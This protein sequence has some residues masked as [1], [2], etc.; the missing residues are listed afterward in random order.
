M[1]SFKKYVSCLF[2]TCK[3]RSREIEAPAGRTAHQLLK[4]RLVG[5][6]H[7]FCA[8]LFL[9]TFAFPFGKLSKLHPTSHLSPLENKYFL[10]HISTE[11]KA[12][13]EI[14]MLV[15]WQQVKYPVGIK[16]PH[17]YFFPFRAYILP[18][19]HPG[20]RG[21][22]RGTHGIISRCTSTWPQGKDNHATLVL[23]KDLWSNIVTFLC[24]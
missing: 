5:T 4:G 19:L 13:K 20:G 6:S 24:H 1:M 22:C 18:L 11:S 9:S 14:Y 2:L 3:L 10:F 21:D 12:S 7:L 23:Q 8:L 15:E 16:G 17:D